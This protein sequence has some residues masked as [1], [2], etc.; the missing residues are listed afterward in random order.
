MKKILVIQFRSRPEM[1]LAE[2]GEYTRAAK[3]KADVT[4]ISALDEMLAWDNPAQILLGYG[5]VIFGGSG[6]YDLH[7]DTDPDARMA[8]ARQLLERVTPLIRYILEQDVPMLGICFGHQLI[9]E[10]REGKVNSDPEQAKVGSFD[11]AL[12]PEG[13]QD[14]L[15][16]SLPHM[17]IGQYGHHNSLSSMPEGATLLA[18]SPK[19][20]FSAL[21]YGAHVYTMQFHP[22]L[23]ADDVRWKL[24]N[25]PG[26]LPEGNS[27]EEIIKPSL[28]ASSL[29]PSFI[30][31]IALS[32]K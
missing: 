11:V 4:F 3:G 5:G 29:I 8:P 13:E 17:F 32:S 19:C 28:E 1:V 31:Y 7:S 24:A 20:K 12:T 9:G 16:S 25:S 22:E 30:E 6:E 14:V 15:F 10:V 23:T 21:R 2:Q 18:S 27:L 26:Y